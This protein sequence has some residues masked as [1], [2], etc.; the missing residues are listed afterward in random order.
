MGGSKTVG[1]W[2]KSEAKDN[3]KANEATKAKG[4]KPKSQLIV[5]QSFPKMDRARARAKANN[6]SAAN[7]LLGN[8]EVAGTT[9]SGARQTNETPRIIGLASK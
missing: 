8:N 7:H 4:G 2:G 3:A 6:T 1:F 5:A 9:S